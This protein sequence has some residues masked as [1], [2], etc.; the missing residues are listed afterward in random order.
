MSGAAG[1]G[2][3]LGLAGA[4]GDRGTVVAAANCMFP[5]NFLV[6]GSLSILVVIGNV[7]YLSLMRAVVIGVQLFADDAGVC[8]E[9]CDQ[10]IVNA[11]EL[12]SVCIK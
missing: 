1:I 10:I 2:V 4:D 5:S 7:L 6:V 12:A 3:V 9:N 11:E 8:D